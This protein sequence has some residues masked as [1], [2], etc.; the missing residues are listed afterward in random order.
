MHARHVGIAVADVAWPESTRDAGASANAYFFLQ[1]VNNFRHGMTI[2]RPHVD[3]VVGGCRHVQRH[4]KRLGHIVDVDEVPAFLAILED[5][6]IA[7]L[8][9]RV[10]KDRQDAGI[11]ITKRLP[12][13]VDVLQTEGDEGNPDGGTRELAQDRKSVVEGKQ[14][15]ASV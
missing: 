9:E 15:T 3:N 14:S 13:T 8:L 1:Q 4:S 6:N 2:A 12:R 11:G 7:T 5:V 10:G